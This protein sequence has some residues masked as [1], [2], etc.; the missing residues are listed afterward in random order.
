MADAVKGIVPPAL[1]L[2]RT[3]QSGKDREKG[4]RG[5]GDRRKN[6]PAPAA[7]SEAEKQK[8]QADESDKEKTKGKILDISA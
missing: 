1:S 4:P 2:N 7:V 8:E 6:D 5:Q 3:T